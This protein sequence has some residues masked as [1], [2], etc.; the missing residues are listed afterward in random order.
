M[1]RLPTGIVTFVFTDIEGSTRL[2]EQ[3]SQAM[4]A[5][6]ARHDAIMSGAIEAH[7]GRVFRTAGDS[8]CAAF[9]SALA[10]LKASL[11]GPAALVGR[12]L[13]Q[14]RP[15]AGRAAAGAD[16]H[17]YQPDRDAR[18]RLQRPAAQP[19]RQVAGSWPRRPDAALAGHGR[20]GARSDARRCGASRHGRALSA[21]SASPRADL[22]AGRPWPDSR[23]SAT[24]D[25]R[26]PGRNAGRQIVTAASR[27]GAASA[28]SRPKCRTCRGSI[29]TRCWRGIAS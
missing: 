1:A 19:H 28:G 18:R 22:P 26:Q 13:G 6:L 7:Q 8:F 15:P 4:P 10:A 24:Q 5:V 16:R 14:L 9:G 29:T 17:P 25:L 3:R 12:T 21:R 23:F 2:W 20:A 27:R 11:G